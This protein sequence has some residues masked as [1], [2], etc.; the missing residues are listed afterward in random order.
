[1]TTLLFI[2]HGI[3]ES[4]ENDLYP[5]YSEEE[6]SSK[7]VDQI[8]KLMQ[9]LKNTNIDSVYSSSINRACKTA[10]QFAKKR[11]IPCFILEDLKEINLGLWDRLPKEEIK[12]RWPQLWEQAMDD[13]GEIVL[14]EGERFQDTLN[15]SVRAFQKIA[16]ENSNKC[17]AIFLSHDV[18]I[19]MIVMHVLNAPTR[20]YHK[21]QIDCASI[22]KITITN[23]KPQLISLNDTAH[24]AL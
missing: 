21:F 11:N 1:M 13:P 24:L 3:T 22:S 16:A 14:P 7:G 4:N 23:E 10:K 8:D 20:I 9:R 15:R 19:K 6:V 17:I 5:G 18:I 12:R 2:R